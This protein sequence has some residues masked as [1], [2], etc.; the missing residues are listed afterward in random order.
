MPCIYELVSAFTD[1]NYVGKTHNLQKR[2][3]SHKSDFKRYL[4]E[5][6]KS[7][8]CTSI[9]ILQYADADIVELE[10]VL[11]EAN[12]KARERWWIENTPTAVNK[13]IPGRTPVEYFWAMSDEYREDRRQYGREYYA[14]HKDKRQEYNARP[15]VRQRT[16]KARRARV[17]ADPEHKAQLQASKRLWYEKN[18]KDVVKV[19]DKLTCQF[20]CNQCNR[21]ARFIHWR[22]T[23]CTKTRRAQYA[24]RVIGR[25]MIAHTRK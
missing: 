3:G 23:K 8:V 24:E 21:N 7:T 6:D 2:L 18:E 10:E 14:N 20:C 4:R 16:K 11:D 9:Q 25:F 12:V 19:S 1:A 17:K 5:G 13:Y 22:T 15:E